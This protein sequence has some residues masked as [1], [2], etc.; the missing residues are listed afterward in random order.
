MKVVRK[1]TVGINMHR[2]KSTSGTVPREFSSRANEKGCQ[3]TES[4]PRASESDG[5]DL[6]KALN[7]ILSGS[8]WTIKRGSIQ[9]SV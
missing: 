2:R 7:G 6:R 8:G 5:G 1:E 3:T 4:L 9:F